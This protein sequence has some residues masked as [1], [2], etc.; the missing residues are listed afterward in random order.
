METNQFD[1]LIV[2]EDFSPYKSLSVNLNDITKLQNYILEAQ[3]QDIAPA[4]GEGLYADLIAHQ[5][6]TNYQTLLNG[7][8]Y[9]NPQINQEIIFPGLKAA[10]V[11]YSYAR[12][13]RF[14]NITPTPSGFVTKNNDYASQI[15]EKALSSMIQQAESSGYAYLR[16]VLTYL[17][18]KRANYPLW[19]GTLEVRKR[20]GTRIT[21]VGKTYG[22][23][24]EKDGKDDPNYDPSERKC[25]RY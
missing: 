20:R 13:I 10:I 6:D 8:R 11:Y 21:S 5:S 19:F 25:D 18:H 22:T 9:T 17:F 23:L 16:K 14:A 12:Y 7:E 15:S 24:F 4:L 2:K 1:L 3:M